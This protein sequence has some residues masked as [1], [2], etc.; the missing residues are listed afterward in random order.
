MCGYSCI[1]N[2]CMYLD[3]AGGGAGVRAGVYIYWYVFMHTS[4]YMYIHLCLYDNY[5]R[6]FIYLVYVYIIVNC[7][8]WLGGSCWCE[9]RRFNIF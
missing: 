7:G 4:K 8:R 1:W 3:L 6:V 2:M 5:I 9:Q